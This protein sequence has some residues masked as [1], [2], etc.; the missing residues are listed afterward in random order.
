MKRI[1]LS[2]LMVLFSM[3]ISGAEEKKLNIVTDEWSPYEFK[4]GE[5]G[6]EYISGF[7]TEII[8]AVLKKMNVPIN[9]R[10]KQYPWVRAD[11]MVREGD[12]D[13]LYT[14]ANSE[15]REKETHYVYEPLIESS[16]SFFIRKEDEGKIKYDSFEDLKG[17]KIGVVRGYAYTPEFWDYIKKE[18][19]FEEVNV[20]ELNIKKLIG[21]RFNIIIMDYVNGLSL[22]KNMGLTDKIVVLPKPLKRISL[23]AV[24][25]KKTIDKDFVDKFTAELKAFKATQDYKT[26]YEKYISK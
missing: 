21:K 15:E 23:Y 17:H 13:L 10:I 2:V 6:N 7:S 11:K 25:S 18:N 1:V 4:A 22:L 8:M 16:W 12:A 14:A 19:S 3:S 9:N 26:I 5:S 20:D 24:F